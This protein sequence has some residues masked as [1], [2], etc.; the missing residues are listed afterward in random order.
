M[1]ACPRWGADV[2][3]AGCKPSLVVL[4]AVA[5]RW[6]L[7][8]EFLVAKDSAAVHWV[9]RD[10]HKEYVVDAAPARVSEDDVE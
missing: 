9:T 5:L 1:R 3:T 2:I 6:Q 8:F 4:V 7:R 10:Q